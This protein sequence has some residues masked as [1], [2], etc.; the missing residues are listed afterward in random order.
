MALLVRKKVGG[1]VVAF[2]AAVGATASGL[3]STDGPAQTHG[4][5]AGRL[6]GTRRV[7]RRGVRAQA[8]ITCCQGGSE[9]SASCGEGHWWRRSFPPRLSRGATASDGR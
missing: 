1:W 5:P 6:K 2:P 8:P 4:G 3:H 9:G 7:P